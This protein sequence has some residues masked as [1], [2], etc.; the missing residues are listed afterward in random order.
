MRAG[1][2]VALAALLLACSSPEPA[3]MPHVVTY[4][5]RFARDVGPATRA[6]VGEGAA[7]WTRTGAVE[8]TIGADWD[9][10][11]A[12]GDRGQVFVGWLAPDAPELEGAR[13]AGFGSSSPVRFVGLVFGEAYGDRVP[14]IAA[15]ELGHAMGLGHVVEG[16]MAPEFDDVERTPTCEDWRAFCSV[17]P[18]P[19]EPCP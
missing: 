15:H 4:E 19:S 12:D 5:L 14:R 7:E 2:L 16:V 3:P 17:H 6:A 9:E 13:L 11:P 1:A 8:L 18:C 10:L